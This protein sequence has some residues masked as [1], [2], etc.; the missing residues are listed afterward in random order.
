[1]LKY[2]TPLVKPLDNKVDKDKSREDETRK[3]PED[4]D[5]TFAYI[6]DAQEHVEKKYPASETGFL[7]RADCIAM[8]FDNLMSV[9]TD[10][11]S[12]CMFSIIFVWIYLT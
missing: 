5:L 8:Q 10:D 3:Y 6:K 12:K 11:T 4:N 7:T 9:V 1:M 2:G